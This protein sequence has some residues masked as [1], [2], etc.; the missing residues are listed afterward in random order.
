MRVQGLD[1]SAAL[2]KVARDRG[3]SLPN[4]TFV[5]AD[6]TIWD[7][8]TFSP[9]LLI[10][11]HGVMFFDDPVA[12]FVNLRRQSSSGATFVFSCFRAPSENEWIGTL[13]AIDPGVAQSQTS[14]SVPGPFAFA[15][16]LAVETLLTDA[17]WSEPDFQ[18]VDYAMVVGLGANA[19]DEALAYFLRI[20]PLARYFAGLDGAAHGRAIARLRRILAR[21]EHGGM[22]AMGAAAW[23]VTARCPD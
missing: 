3:K 7:D 8:P 12:A 22:V 23:I 11:R 9:D 4:L 5:Q 14:P 17:G 20:G 19:I 13:A 21:H 16:R 10:S 2:L 18:P 1:V 15:D 6:A